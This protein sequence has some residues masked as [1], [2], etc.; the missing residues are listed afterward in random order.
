M[1]QSKAVQNEA[2]RKQRSIVLTKKLTMPWETFSNALKWEQG[3]HVTIIGATGQGKTHLIR[4]LERRRKWT[5][6]FGTKPSGK[7][8]TVS[9]FVRDGYVITED[10]PAQ[11]GQ[12]KVVLWPRYVDPDDIPHQKAVFSKALKQMFVAGRWSIAID[13]LAYFYSDLKIKAPI[14]GLLQQGRSLDLS[15]V[16]STQRPFFVPLLAYSQATHLFLYRESDLRNIKRAMEFSGLN[17]SV[18]RDVLPYLPQY[19]FLY[20]N[21]RT[22]EVAISKAPKGD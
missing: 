2:E 6:L 21:T 17:A 15:L 18:V 20:L 4:H 14:E 3:E 13:E 12:K 5:V 9:D 1:A 8:P 7:D 11:I 19:T 22:G 16:T 10:W